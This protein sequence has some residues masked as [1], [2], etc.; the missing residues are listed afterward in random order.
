MESAPNNDGLLPE[1]QALDPF[2][3]TESVTNAPDQ[4][5]DPTLRVLK[6]EYSLYGFRTVHESMHRFGED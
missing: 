1:N 4:S 3:V 2:S 6:A 5:D